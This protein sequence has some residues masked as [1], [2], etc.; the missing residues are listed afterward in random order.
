MTSEPP[1]DRL[2]E[3]GVLKRR[4]IEAR[5]VAPLLERLSE[6]F[7]SE[8]YDT[9]RDVI[10][11]VARE[12]GAALAE[13]VG[14][15]SLPGFASALGAWSADGALETEMRELSDEVFAFDVVRCRYAEMY[16]AL[17]LADLGA[18]MSCN[19]DGSLIEG[20]NPDVVFTRTQTIMSG[21][22]HCDFRFELPATPVEIQR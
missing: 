22:D 15:D 20:F 14:D 1:T 21:A 9:A 2:N 11:D 12:Q 6:R 13:L 17:G 16:R 7:G 8:V 18:T 10:V 5:I 19:R 4:E 3:V